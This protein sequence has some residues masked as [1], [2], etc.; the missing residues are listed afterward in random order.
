[1]A[2][3]P[4]VINMLC[5]TFFLCRP[6]KYTA[7]VADNSTFCLEDITIYAGYQRVLAPLAAA[8][9]ANH[10][11]FVT[12][13]F[14]NQKNAVQSEVVGLGLS[15]DPFICRVKAIS[16]QVRHLRQHNTP[17]ATTLCTYYM[18]NKSCY[19]TPTNISVTLKMP[20][21]ALGATLGLTA[22][23]VSTCSLRTAAVMSLLCAHIDSDTIR[24]LGHWR[25][26]ESC[27]T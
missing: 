26:H 18:N 17:P 20:V 6:G 14:I 15:G 11:T 3:A 27:D 23:E 5:I 2:E 24:L 25:S 8:A 4:A 13:T 10:A 7:P 16:N 19:V 12:L 9:A 1:M 22:K 21:L